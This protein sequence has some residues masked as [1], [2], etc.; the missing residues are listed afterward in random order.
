MQITFYFEIDKS[1][2]IAGLVLAVYPCFVFPLRRKM[3]NEAGGGG[4]WLL[5]VNPR[6]SNSSRVSQ[7]KLTTGGICWAGPI[8]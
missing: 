1:I 5:V 6:E 2:V 3:R 4:V 7:S 8:S